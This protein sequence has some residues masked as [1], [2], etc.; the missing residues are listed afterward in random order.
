MKNIVMLEEV[1]AKNALNNLL[2]KSELEERS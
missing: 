1:L 2:L